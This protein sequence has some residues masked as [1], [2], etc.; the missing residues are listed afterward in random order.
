MVSSTAPRTL[1]GPGPLRPTRAKA[2]DFPPIAKAYTRVSQV[3]RES[4]LLRRTPWFYL[5]VGTALL[6]ALGGAITGF[7]LLGETWYQLLIAAALGII[8]TQIAFLAHEAAHRQ[9]LSTGPAN[10]RL[11][12]ILA[13]AIGMSYSWWDSKHSRHHSN[14]NRVGKDP[15]IEVDTISFLEEDAVE[16]RG[17]RRMLTKRQG[18]FFFPLL[19]LEGLNLH[20]QSFGH[21]ASREPVRGR[22]IEIGI[23]AARFA[24]ILVPVFLLLPFG[25][26][27]AFMGVQFAVFGVYMGAS[28][29]PNHKGMPVI[30]HDA[31]LDFFT[32][33]VRT[34]RNIRG[35]WWAT[36]LMG[37]LNYQ[38]EHHLFPSM[39]RP[40]LARARA[41]VREHCRT[42]GV[43]YT[44]TSL[45]RSYAIVIAYLNRVGLAARDPFECPITAEYRRA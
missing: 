20:R 21:L 12:R 1:D 18:W 25:M 34:S 3:V 28:F 6:L 42:L 31:K 15:D 17:F 23:I 11:A 45:W 43:P 36:W 33:Q 19:T 8:F 40:H 9:I 38:V 7:I 13:G 26:A 24:L 35:G 22:W 30:A 44:E 27:C 16:A 10:D 2:G 41:I 5:A 4:G 14:P 32:K 37:G 39:A 29:A